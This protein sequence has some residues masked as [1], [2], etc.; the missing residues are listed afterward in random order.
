MADPS[1]VAAMPTISVPNEPS[2][3]APVESKQSG[4]GLQILDYSSIVDQDHPSLDPWSNVL[5]RVIK[6][7]VTIKCTSLRS[8]D[9][10]FAGNYE[11]TGF[12]VDSERGIILSNRHIV[13]QGPTTAIAIFGNYEE[14]TLKQD[15][16]DPVHDFGFFRYD[17]AK[18]KFAKVE[19]IELYPEGAKIGLDIKVCGNNAGEKLSILSAT[20]ARLDRDAPSFSSGY[21]DFN[22]NYFQAASGTTG[23]SSGS[24]VL[25]SYGRAIALNVGGNANLGSGFFLP[26][27]P[28]VRALKL[29]Q[30]GKSVPRGTLQTI[31]VHS[32]YDQLK[33]IGLPQDVEK[34]C[35]ERN[36]TG[37]GLLS[38]SQVLLEGPGYKAGLAVGDVLI[39][40]D[41]EAFGRRFIDSFSSLWEIIDAS[42]D[43]EISLTVYRGKQRKEVT[44]TVQDLHSI[45]PSTFLEAG[46]AILHPLSYQLAITYHM[47]CKGLYVAQSG[48][49]NW[50]GP[51][52][53]FLITQLNGQA[54]DSL[55]TFQRVFLSIPDGNRVEFKYVILGGCEEYPAI[56][57]IDHR[58]YAAA[59][60]SRNGVWT[61][62][63][64]VRPSVLEPRRLRRA[65]TLMIEGAETDT[66][67]KILTLI[68]CRVPIAADVRSLYL[69]DY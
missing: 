65:P 44:A 66:L 32:S 13:N 35:R 41:Q 28:V 34:Q 22:I 24:P 6:A 59:L 55:D 62:K 45:T 1:T 58:F 69:F 15:Y 19:E 4:A 56:V 30:A 54:M 16:S 53:R 11:G 25:D 9:T 14:I 5:P 39:D 48:V 21:N 7:I 61:R 57:E 40:C 10:D 50:L 2:P 47:P 37:T 33:R 23:G 17:P 51:D 64:L 42:V 20:L 31:F 63:L 26:L 68:R 52:G 29:I 27:E 43:K 46:D 8:F 18:V 12:V 38:I 49:F 60:C 67:K 36:K 3:T